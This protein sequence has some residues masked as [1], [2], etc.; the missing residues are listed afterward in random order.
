MKRILLYAL[1]TMLLFS[2]CKKN[3]EK[4]PVFQLQNSVF[5]V[6]EGPFPTGTGTV[7]A[8]NRET[9]EVSVDLFEAA[10]GRPLGNI[11]QSMTIYDGRAYIVVNKAN[12]IEVVNPVDFKSIGTV[13]GLTLPRYFLGHNTAGGVVSCWDSTVN[14]LSLGSLHVTATLR[15]GSGP[16][17]MV[18]C[19]GRIY[20]LNSG[21]FG[22][23]STVSY[24]HYV[25]PN[26]KKITV[27][28][29]PSGIRV[30]KDNNVWVLC[31]GKGYNGFPDPEDTPAKLVCID[32]DNFEVTR[33][34]VFPDNENHPD[35][36]IINSDST[37][38]YYN[39]PR[40]IFAFPVSASA[41]DSQPF[42]PSDKMHY[43]L[44][45]DNKEEMIYASEI[46][47]YAQNGYVY[48]FNASDGSL[49]GSFQAGIVP[50]GF[51]FSD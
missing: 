51:C 4:D 43:A 20:A 35:N 11:V 17:E 28:H 6:N 33:E 12:K 23:D 41:L 38:L 31:S 46:P 5:I 30:D 10:N 8:Y 9:G 37:I 16:D 32:P 40:G 34:F 7:M 29:R 39:H 15:V 22:M 27:G 24:F 48:I 42:I 26:E 14:W 13:E 44:G 36:L 25:S 3:N 50:G 19:K 47:D 2:G 21:G 49:A 1:S 18:Y 45:F